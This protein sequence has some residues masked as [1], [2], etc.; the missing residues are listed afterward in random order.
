MPS[1]IH[2]TVSISPGDQ[3][4]GMVSLNNTGEQKTTSGDQ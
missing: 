1:Q 3:W 2:S 4:Y